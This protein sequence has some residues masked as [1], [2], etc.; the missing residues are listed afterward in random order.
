MNNKN[1]NN[2]KHSTLLFLPIVSYLDLDVQKKGI[3][4]DNKEKTG[5]YRWTHKKSGKSYIGSAIDLTNRF[6]NY[7]NV[8]Y[9]ERETEKNSSII[10][11]ALLKHG[12]VS[13]KLDILEYCSFPVLI[14]K[15]QYYLNLFKPEYNILNFAASV[16]G[17]KHTEAT[18]ELIRGSKLGRLRTSEAK[19][20]ISLGSAQAQ[21]VIVKENQTGITTEFTS[22]RKAAVYVGLHHSYIAKCLQK[23]N[24]YIGETYTIVKKSV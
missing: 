5:V 1:K 6:K 24:I 18:V 13:F 3:L 16:S 19:L 7:F 8:S 15:E 9:L 20:K 2:N 4:K 22:V 14:E 17:L 11:R 10:Y 21:P 23:N 12:Y